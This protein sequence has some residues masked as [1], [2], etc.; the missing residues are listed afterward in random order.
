MR[1]K[2]KIS[3]HTVLLTSEQLEQLSVLLCNAES[4][5]DKWVGAGKG[6]TG[7]NNAYLLTIHPFNPL[8][9]LTINVV[10]DEQVEAIKFVQKQQEKSE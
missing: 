3:D 10:S 9:Q 1:F 6:T 4:M 5:H 7:G 8:E 2:V